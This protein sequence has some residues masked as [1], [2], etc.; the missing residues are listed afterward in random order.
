MRAFLGIPVPE[1]SKSRIISIQKK[2]SGFDIKLVEPE[3][4]HFNLKFFGDI[5]DEQISK[6]KGILTDVCVQFKPF[7]IKISGLGAFPNKDYIRVVW[8]GVKDGHDE[9][10]S[11]ADSVQK[12]IKSLGFGVEDRFVP[13]LTLGR[14]R[15]GRNM[16]GL[17][18]IL[19]DMIGVEIGNMK[20]SKL[21]LFQ[22]KLGP[23]G[24]TYEEVF[25]TQLSA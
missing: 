20:I 13:H 17:S 1:E 24:P 19:D 23:N 2:F 15:S 21:I 25:N 8:I 3:N 11:L 16:T 12:S 7:E 9:I 4:L 22:S 18:K 10:V 6:L 14:V 5:N